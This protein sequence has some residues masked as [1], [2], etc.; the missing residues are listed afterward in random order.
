MRGYLLI[1]ALLALATALAL[2][3]KWQLG[4]LRSGLFALAAALLAAA[5]LSPAG[6]W[7]GLTELTGSPTPLPAGATPTGIAV[8]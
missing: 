7:L 3:W 2:G 1:G 8:S 6:P 5:A 4:M